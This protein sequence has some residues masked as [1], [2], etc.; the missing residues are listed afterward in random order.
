[1]MDQLIID[2]KTYEK[3]TQWV[4]E[5]RKYPEHETF[6]VG[7]YFSQSFIRSVLQGSSKKLNRNWIGPVRIQTVLDNT[8]YLCSDWSGR[9]IP[10]DS[11]LIG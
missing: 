3:N 8:H 7:D 2:R 11:T 5:I 6:A 1:M 10:K 4:R 9:L